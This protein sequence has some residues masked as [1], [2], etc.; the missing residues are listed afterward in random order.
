VLYCIQRK[1]N[2]RK[3]EQKKEKNKEQKERKTI[4]FTRKGEHGLK[5][6]ALIFGTTYAIIVTH[7]AVSRV[8]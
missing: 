3:K 8:K 7:A 6:A 1:E 4:K 5:L 2:K